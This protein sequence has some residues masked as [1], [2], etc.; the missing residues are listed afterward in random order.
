MQRARD[1]AL[2]LQSSANRRTVMNVN[3]PSNI[4]NA[5]F[6]MLSLKSL[7]PHLLCWLTLVSVC[8]GVSSILELGWAWAS[9]D[10]QQALQLALL[11]MQA[12]GAQLN[13]QGFLWAWSSFWFSLRSW[14]STG[15]SLPSFCPQNKPPKHLHYKFCPLC[16]CWRKKCKM[17]GEGVSVKI[18][19]T[20]DKRREGRGGK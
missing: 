16:C 15:S 2:Y 17:R 5:Y 7:T 13:S 19:A 6:L 20:Q 4:N 18:S 12:W 11:A 1:R 3:R 9:V 14:V 8:L 10:W